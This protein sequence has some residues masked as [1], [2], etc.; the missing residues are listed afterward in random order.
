MVKWI[1]LPAA[2]AALLLAPAV[3]FSAYAQSVGDPCTGTNRSYTVS[4]VST[5][6]L[7]CNGTTLELLEKD[8][9]NP[10]RKGIGTSSP[11]ATLHVNGE[12]IIG[13]TGLVCSGTTAGGLRWSSGSSCIQF[14]NGTSWACV[15]QPVGCDATPAAFDFTDQSGLTASTL[16]TSNVLNINGTDPGCNVVVSVS[17]S[18]SPQFRVCSDSICTSVVQNWTATNT[19]LDM[20][21]KY[22]QL[23]AT[24]DANPSTT[25]NVTATV[26]GVSNTWSITTTSTGPCGDVGPGDEGQICSD[27]SVYAGVSP[28]GNR[29]MYVARCDIGMSWDGSNCTGTRSY[30]PWNNGNTSSGFTVTGITGTLTGAYNT[31][32][33]ITLDSDSGVG[34][35]QQ[36]QTAQA[37]ADL[38]VH[39]QTDWYHPAND[40]L[41]VIYENLY[42]GTPNDNLPNP[43]ISGFSGGNY[44]ASTE[45]S[46]T[47]AYR[48]DFSSGSLNNINKGMTSPVRCAR[49]D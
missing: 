5:P 11:A 4:G 19:S 36:H 25:V 47:N 18:G 8:L 2:S 27:G 34:G 44:F 29:N 30:L 28:D 14:C 23:Q 33:L 31:S 49:K 26:G 3:F 41:V 10:V 24:T 43:V 20:N 35:I 9:S 22:L 17:G 16:T 32:E 1:L 48:R 42:D 37:C 46:T 21:G 7:I 38:N 15:F 12:T 6:A 13:N 39:G 40:E 45:A